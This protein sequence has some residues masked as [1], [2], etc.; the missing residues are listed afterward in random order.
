M[1]LQ[2]TPTS[3]KRKRSRS[4][5]RRHPPSRFKLFLK[6]CFLSFNTLCL[7]L[8]IFIILIGIWA[9]T[10]KE[11][12]NTDI[13]QNLLLDPVFILFITGLITF[14]ISCSGVIAS[15]KENVT[16]LN[17][18]TISLITLLLIEIIFGIFL[19]TF[20]ELIKEHSK[21]GFRSLIGHYREDPDQQNIIDWVQQ[22]WLK[23]CGTDGP[24]DW[25]ENVYFNC[26]NDENVNK[27]VCGVP[28]SCCR[29]QTDV[30]FDNLTECGSNIR[31]NE[32]KI[33]ISKIIYEK[34][35]IQALEEWLSRNLLLV[36]FTIICTLFAQL[37]IVCSAQMLRALC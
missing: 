25:E 6:Y 26:S 36:C 13:S 21:H 8:A 19:I 33:D 20:K 10:E 31:R 12:Y 17:F 16:I 14:T 34:G 9:W 2:I 18:Y 35:C 1:K 27:E 29:H 24:N 11:T 23:C 22:N 4:R 32:N 15:L 3:S 37:L 7:F 5:H 28:F 30:S